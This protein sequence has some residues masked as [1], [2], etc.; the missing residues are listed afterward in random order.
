MNIVKIE[1]ELKRMFDAMMQS[2]DGLYFKY[3]YSEE[4]HAF[5]VAALIDEERED[6]EDYCKMAI[7]EENRLNQMFGDEAPLFSDNEVLFKL[8]TN[9]KIV[10]LYKQGEVASVQLLTHI[11]SLPSTDWWSP[12]VK[13]DVQSDVSKKTSR[14]THDNML[15]AAA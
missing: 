13:A 8:S 1:Y 5:L 11:V 14:R 2:F 10:S 6:Y 15:F 7:C 12:V 4:R 9:A 3:E